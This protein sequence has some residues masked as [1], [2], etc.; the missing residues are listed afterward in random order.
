M[1]FD[2]LLCF[3]L[4]IASMAYS[5]LFPIP[6]DL[7]CIIACCSAALRVRLK[8]T[9]TCRSGGHFSGMQ[10]AF[11]ISTAR[12]V[13]PMDATERRH[14]RTPD[15][16]GQDLSLC[17]PCRTNKSAVA[18]RPWVGDP[19]AHMNRTIGNTT[20]KRHHPERQD[21]LLSHLADFADAYHHALRL[22]TLSGLT[23]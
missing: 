10:S 23:T 22:Q 2:A 13:H 3:R 11:Y 4:M 5:S 7:Y 16:A 8:W 21:L 18:Q 12:Q 6:R 1:P 15:R 9:G 14:R 20:V 17:S 19:V